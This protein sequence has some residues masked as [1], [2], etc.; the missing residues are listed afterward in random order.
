MRSDIEAAA[1]RMVSKFGAK[2][3]LKALPEH[4]WEGETVHEVAS[5][6]YAD[7]SGILV[8]TDR[9]LLF[10][11]KGVLSSKTEDFAY[12]KISSLEHK[13][14]MM[15]S[16]ITIYVSNQKAE[17]KNLG[18]EESKRITDFTRNKMNN[19]SHKDAVAAPS[20]PSE[21]ISDQLLKLKQLHDAGVLSDEEYS[22]KSA[23]LIAQL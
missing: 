21:S 16:S 14:G 4:L 3:E 11:V 15:L 17:I 22:A 9:R 6:L 2:R 18:K 20:V 13:N 5:G 8:A 12:D 7:G 10:F 1:N 23:P 19:P